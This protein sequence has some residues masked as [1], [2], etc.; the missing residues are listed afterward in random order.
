MAKRDGDLACSM[1][2]AFDEAWAAD[3]N[4]VPLYLLNGSLGAGKTSVLEYLL[5]CPAFQGARVI[6]NEFANENVDGYRLEGL[7]ELVT[8]LSGDCVCCGSE[9]ALTKMLM[10]FSRYSAAPVFIEATGVART[11]N[12]V[13]RLIS[14]K[15]FERYELMQ[16]WYVI[17]AHEILHGV[18]PAHEVELQAADMVLVTKEDLLRDDERAAYEARRAALPYGRIVSAPYGRFDLELVTPPSGLLRFFDEYDGEL[19]VPDNPSYSVVD[20]SSLRTSE[21]AYQA[22]WPELFASYGLRRM[23]GCFV[24]ETGARRHLEATPTQLDITA[25]RSDEAAKLVLIGERAEAIHYDTLAA[26]LAVFG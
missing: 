20:V 12:L 22:L 25:G 15:M 6:E 3:D 13:E 10:D 24:D 17:D 18:E 5:R 11:M 23:K 21:A 14:A 16:S 9:D 4:K 26:M 7:A 8:T 1:L 19:A 2:A